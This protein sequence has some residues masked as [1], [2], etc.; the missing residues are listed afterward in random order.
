MTI[1]CCC[2]AICTYTMPSIESSC[3]IYRSIVCSTSRTAISLAIITNAVNRCRF[4]FLTIPCCCAAICTYTMPSIKSICIS[5]HS[6]IC[7]TSRTAISLAIIT[8]A[9]DRCRFCFLTIPCS[10][11]AICT[12]TMPSIESSCISYRSIIYST[13]RTAISL[14]IITNAVNRC[15]FCFLTICSRSATM[16]AYTMPCIMRVCI[17]Y[18]RIICSTSRAVISLAVIANAVDRYCFLTIF[19]VEPPF[20]PIQCHL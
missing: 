17:S 2:A 15:S 8:N 18:S 5:Y 12:Y 7:S 20:A 9:I 19:A 6:I 10:R 1:P 3:I 16:S 4:C 14:A 13:S 11:A